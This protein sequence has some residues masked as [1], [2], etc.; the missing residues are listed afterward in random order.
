MNEAI[1]YTALNW[2]RQELNGKL[3]QARQCLEEFAESPGNAQDLEACAGSLHE[4]RGPL[5]MLELQGAERLAAEIE[6][7]VTALAEGR[8]TPT[9]ENLETLMQAFVQLPDY[10]SRLGGGH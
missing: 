3:Q 10:L 8:M 2:V 6:S 4:A 5:R 9:A 7:A 1:D